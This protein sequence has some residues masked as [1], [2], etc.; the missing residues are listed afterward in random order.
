MGRPGTARK[1]EILEAVIE[2]ITKN[3][4]A[5]LSLR[6]LAAATGT[7][8]RLLIYHFGSKEDLLA[9]AM[10]A[11]RD[12]VQQAFAGAPGS[13]GAATAGILARRFWRRATHKSNA[14]ILRVFFEVLAL[15]L[16]NSGKYGHYMKGSA[17]SWHRLFAAS[18]PRHLTPARRKIFA[19]LVVDTFNGLLLDYL[20]TGNLRRTTR[21]LDIFAIEIDR[22][23]LR[24]KK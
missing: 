1:E 24:R 16:T 7:K 8:A 14:G 22:L 2:Y 15:A 6:P 11:L 4:V 21:A 13:Q 20:V 12:R 18:M 10:A 19:T 23:T 9:E 17:A 3:G 5:G